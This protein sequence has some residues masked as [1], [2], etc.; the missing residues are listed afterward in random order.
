MSEG[1]PITPNPENQ[2]ERPNQD[3]EKDANGLEG[4]TGGETWESFNKEITNNIKTLLLRVSKLNQKGSIDQKG[5]QQAIRDLQE[6]QD[7]LE[8][9]I[10]D[11]YFDH[12]DELLKKHSLLQLK[13]DQ[14]ISRVQTADTPSP[15]Q[16]D[17]DEQ[18]Q[19]RFEKPSKINN[20]DLLLADIQPRITALKGRLSRDF[21]L[22]NPTD[23]TELDSIGAE[24]SLEQPKISELKSALAWAER[25]LAG[26]VSRDLPGMTDDE[27]TDYEVELTTQIELASQLAKTY[28]E[29][30]NLKLQKELP[31]PE[32]ARASYDSV[33]VERWRKFDIYELFRMW[34]TGSIAADSEPK[35]AYD[36]VFEEKLDEIRAD[37]IAKALEVDAGS[38]KTEETIRAEAEKRYQDFRSLCEMMNDLIDFGIMSAASL[39]MG[40]LTAKHETILAKAASADAMNLN[41]KFNTHALVRSEGVDQ[42]EQYSDDMGLVQR[43]VF[44]M[45]QELKKK[46]NYPKD[47][48]NGQSTDSRFS[49]NQ[50]FSAN[51]SGELLDMVSGL[52]RIRTHE[53]YGGNRL[54]IL[55]IGQELRYYPELAKKLL[56]HFAKQKAT[57]DDIGSEAGMYHLGRNKGAFKFA[58]GASGRPAGLLPAILYQ[59][60]KNSARESHAAMLWFVNPTKVDALMAFGRPG[61]GEDLDDHTTW[62]DTK[63][64][65]G[66]PPRE[67]PDPEARQNKEVVRVRKLVEKY[68]LWANPQWAE[69]RG[70][71]PYKPTEWYED[72]PNLSEFFNQSEATVLSPDYIQSRDAVLKIIEMAAQSP[73]TNLSTITTQMEEKIQVLVKTFNSEIGKAMAYIGPYALDTEEEDDTKKKFKKVLEDI[74]EVKK[75]IE[76]SGK[77]EDDPDNQANKEKLK[78]LQKEERRLRPKY[79]LQQNQYVHELIIACYQFFLA[80]ILMSVPSGDIPLINPGGVRTREYDTLYVRAV[81]TMRNTISQN[82]TLTRYW[83]MIIGTAAPAN[84][85]HPAVDFIGQPELKRRW[86]EDARLANEYLRWVLEN[87]P[88]RAE[89]GAFERAKYMREERPHSP[90]NVKE[91]WKSSYQDPTEQKM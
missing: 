8:L 45:L 52:D 28:Q 58:D 13:I 38:G 78:E 11:E 54:E 5:T 42:K 50:G 68:F 90:I 47:P 2:E 74:R 70:F 77:P 88:D 1:T 25:H 72:F 18:P 69:A 23:K 32:P 56:K 40:Q 46:G 19:A 6:V 60:G 7:R 75:E 15:Q 89:M 37:F 29:L 33:T 66:A 71:L 67:V 16:Q 34:Y 65:P 39:N 87:E 53:G 61:P 4:E 86:R 62:K 9:A 10:V 80:N 49:R 84:S 59:V 22:D 79:R 26:V 63:I 17:A 14:L 36:V 55:N 91:G 44:A 3:A 82:T 81:K 57:R 12:Y 20:L 24:L 31:K 85:K 51:L 30:I 21:D 83:P 43:M 73:L 64:E 35:Q 48:G 27:K 76:D 41:S